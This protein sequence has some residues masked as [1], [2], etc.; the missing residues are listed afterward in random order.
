MVTEFSF[1]DAF[2][3]GV[4]IGMATVLMFLCN[5]R[6]TG[7]SGIVGALV[8]PQAGQVSW[9]LVFI[10]SLMAGGALYP[11][12]WGRELE[13]VTHAP[14][15][16]YVIAGLLVG[17]GT[18]LGSGCTSGHGICGLARFSPRSIVATFI[19]IVTAALTHTLVNLV[20]G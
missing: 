18:R 19:F 15:F 4:I 6:I 2:T 7:I 8:K 17:I 14:G 3:G 11:L 13:V 1:L 5:G 12:V 10:L 20:T 16:V 9:R